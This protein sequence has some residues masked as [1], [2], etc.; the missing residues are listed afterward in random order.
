M[1]AVD[2]VHDVVREPRVLERGGERR[3]LGVV[4]RDDA[5]GLF[6]LVVLARDVDDRVDLFH[7]LRQW[8]SASVR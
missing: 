7:I 5:V 6:E 4:W 1:E 8:A 3:A 2:V